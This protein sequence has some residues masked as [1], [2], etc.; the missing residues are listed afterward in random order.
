ASS[1]DRAA[2]GTKPRSTPLAEQRAALER[3]LTE[4]TNSPMVYAGTFTPAPPTHRLYRGD[5]L[6]KREVIAPAA[7]SAFGAKLSPPAATPEQQRRLALAKWI[8]DPRHPLTAR[9]I[10]N[11][12]WHYHFGTGLVATPSDFGLNGA[13]PSHP[14][15]LDWLADELVRSG[16]SLKHI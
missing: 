3:K 4:L 7:L 1:D 9:V 12:L 10:V 5:P 14:E 6:Q 13:K 16:W 15:L 8:A 2:F 11:R